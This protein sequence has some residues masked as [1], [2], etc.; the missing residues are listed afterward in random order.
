MNPITKAMILGKEKIPFFADVRT[1]HSNIQ[2]MKRFHSF[3]KF[4]MYGRYAKEADWVLEVAIGR[5]GDIFKWVDAGIKNIVGIDID[6]NA[7]KEG[8]AFVA[9]LIAEGSLK[10]APNIYSV[11]GNFSDDIDFLLSGIN[12]KYELGIIEGIL[13]VV[14][15]QF[16]MHFFTSSAETLEKFAENVRRLLKKG[17]IF[18]ATTMDAHRLD[19]LLKV[20]KIEDGESFDLKMKDKKT[21]KLSTVFSIRRLYDNTSKGKLL[22]IGQQVA[23][24]VESIGSTNREYLVNF[25]YVS[26][27]FKKKGMELIKKM[28]FEEVYPTWKKKREI[29]MTDVEKT[30]SFLNSVLVF[31]KI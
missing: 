3:I 17:G 26:K 7:I 4:Q 13:D 27:V 19:R 18:M 30:F 24:F 2:A 22:D 16:A 20:N 12:E 6:K 10:K 29:D 5:Y 31:K 15:C 14:S 9:N 11:V 21:G 23:V 1:R 25:D 8:E 28:S